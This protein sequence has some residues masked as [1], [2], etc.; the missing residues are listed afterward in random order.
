MKKSI[1]YFVVLLFFLV[2][3]AAKAQAYLQKR[4]D[5]FYGQFEFAKAIE[6]YQKMVVADIQSSH[7]HKRLADCHM[8]LRDY[9][10]AIPHLN[11]IIDSPDIEVE[12]YFK[13]AMA[14]QSAGDSKT[15]KSYFLKYKKYAKNDSRVKRFL[16]DGDLA[17]VAFNSRER[18]EIW[19]VDFNSPQSDFGAFVYE[20]KLYFSS[21]REESQG[22]IYGW[23]GESWLDIFYVNTEGNTKQA[24]P[25]LGNINT[26]LHESSLVYTADSTVVYFTR[27]NYY[28]NKER[29][30]KSNENLLKIYRAKWTRDGWVVNKS[31]PINSDHYSTGHPFVSPDG[32]RLYYT[33][34][35]PGGYGGTDIYYSELGSRGKIGRSI[36]VGP[37]INTEGDEMFPFIN[38]E[39]TLFFSSDGHL[40]YG[41]LDVFAAITNNKKEVVSVVNQGQPLN[42]TADDF[43]YYSYDNGLRGYVSSNREGGMGG[44]DIYHFKFVPSLMMEGYVSDA[45]NDKVLDSVEVSLFELGKSKPINFMTTG[46]NGYFSF[47]IDRR[48]SYN[49]EAIRR[50]HPIK[51]VYFNTHQVSDRENRLR[52]DFQLEPVLN[53]KVLADL[54][55]IYFDFNKSNIRPDAAKELDKVVKLMIETYPEMV[56]RL[57]S[58]TD[59]IGSHSY[60]DALSQR[61][62]ASTYNYLI[63]QGIDASRILSYKGFGKRKPINDC[64]SKKDCSDEELELN[65]RTEFPIVKLTNTDTIEH[66]N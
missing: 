36:N 38:A 4:A 58:H 8:Y 43:A 63:K 53:V 57:E 24:V 37:K 64:T 40:G 29:N 23:N 66:E 3:H 54:D 65:R 13:Y 2:A 51:V 11:A 28:R 46:K 19:P 21:A 5:Y 22:D 30:S 26:K 17:N 20:N 44:D 55:K 32:K 49:L 45:I 25:V 1:L 16:K 48:K 42:S 56:I 6:A 14:L 7:A 33:S 60:N 59:P 41:Q 34:N 12:Y 9:K 39:G 61:R 15:A 18:Y 35:R 62:A 52:K 10:R 31:L 27:N 47:F 50:T